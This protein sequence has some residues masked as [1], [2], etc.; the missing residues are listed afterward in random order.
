MALNAFLKIKGVKQGD[1]PGGVTQ[2]GRVGSIAVVGVFHDL[3]SPH[4]PTGLP[5]GKVQVQPLR[6]RKAVDRS[7]PLLY[8]MFATH[9]KCAEWTLQFCATG[10]A[11]AV[12]TIKLN[13]ASI[14]AIHLQE[15]GDQAGPAFLPYEDV[16]FAFDRIEVIWG[17]GPSGQ[18]SVV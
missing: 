8:N 5:T 6:I 10:S 9:E 17:E 18:V 1:I 7:S 2:P 14:T 13:Q 11:I 16:S 12:Y 15:S 4:D 3:T